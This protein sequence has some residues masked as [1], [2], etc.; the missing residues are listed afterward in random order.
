MNSFSVPVFFLQISLPLLCRLARYP[1]TEK[2]SPL[3]SVA[4][5]V[6]ASFFA[7]HLPHAAVAA[8]RHAADLAGV[9]V[10]QHQ[11]WVMQVGN[12]YDSFFT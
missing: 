6:V 1:S 3:A 5:A 10:S 11:Q 2:H 9:S 8:A 4:T 7:L 12:G